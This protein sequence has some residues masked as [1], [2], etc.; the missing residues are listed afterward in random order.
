MN[1]Y[2]SY[3]LPLTPTRKRLIRTTRRLLKNS[4]YSQITSM[5]WQ[6]WWKIRLTFRNTHQTRRIHRLLQTLPPWSQLKR[7]IHH[8]E[9]ETL[10][11]F[12]TCG[13]SNK[14][15]AHQ[16]S[17]SSLSRQNSKET[18][19]WILR[20]SSTTSSFISM[21]RLDS[22][23]TSFLITSPSKD[24]LILKNTLSQIANTLPNRGISR[25]TLPLDT[26]P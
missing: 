2:L 7:G 13:P 16:N 11:K 1:S 24:T 14:R 12:V 10:P 8:W 22:D 18:L 6:H 26:H 3:N 4:H 19:L 5:F 17:M 21:L 25:Y 15:S 9:G 23:K 20:T